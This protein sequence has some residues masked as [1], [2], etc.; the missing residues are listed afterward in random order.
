MGDLK[1]RDLVVI[2]A[3]VLDIS[4]SSA[5]DNAT[6]TVVA[7]NTKQSMGKMV[8][9]DTLN[10]F[11][12][13]VPPNCAYSL[14]CSAP[15]YADETQEIQVDTTQVDVIFNLVSTNNN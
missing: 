8:A 13:G 12:L 9:T 5:I 4:D 2:M 1:G 3:T 11:K 10:K 6:I 14:N 15:G 7:I